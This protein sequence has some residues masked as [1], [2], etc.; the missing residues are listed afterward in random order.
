[1]W[2]V[3]LREV[4]KMEKIIHERNSEKI[5]NIMERKQRDYEKAIEETPEQLKKFFKSK[6]KQ[7]KQVIEKFEQIKALYNKANKLEIEKIKRTPSFKNDF[8]KIE[9]QFQELIKD[10]KTQEDIKKIL[11]VVG[12]R[13]DFPSQ[14][15]NISNNKELRLFTKNKTLTDFSKLT[16]SFGERYKVRLSLIHE[17]NGEIS[18]RHT[19]ITPFTWFN[20]YYINKK[21]D[22]IIPNPKD[23]FYGV[24]GKFPSMDID[25]F[26]PKIQINDTSKNSNLL[27]NL[28]TRLNQYF[29]TVITYESPDSGKMFLLSIPQNCSLKETM[30]TFSKQ[31]TSMHSKFFSTAKGRP[32]TKEYYQSIFDTQYPILRGKKFTVE[33]ACY[34]IARLY[35]EQCDYEISW[36]TVWRNYYQ[37]WKKKQN[38]RGNKK[39]VGIKR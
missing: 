39:K 14:S 3:N 8:E 32:K 22:N 10:K 21:G 9:S 26:I 29:P 33:G 12:H 18:L 7:A 27:R 15:T 1:M 6:S 2:G 25:T 36:N 34:E 11:S 35:K 16:I 24:P 4:T 13:I 5:K 28:S 37:A 30:N 31:V 20:R 19:P 17:L 38:E 23:I